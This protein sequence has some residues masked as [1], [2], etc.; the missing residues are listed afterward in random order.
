MARRQ[1]RNLYREVV[2][3]ATSAGRSITADGS[4]RNFADRVGLHDLQTYSN[5][6]E[7]CGV[8]NE[9]HAL[10]EC[11]GAESN[12]RVRENAYNPDRE[13]GIPVRKRCELKLE[14]Y[15][16]RDLFENLVVTRSTGE[17]VGR[18]FVEHY[19]NPSNGGS[20]RLHESGIDAV[21]YSLFYGI[22]GQLLISQ[23]LG[24]FI[25][26]ENVITNLCGTYQTVMM[27]GE[28]IPGVGLP[29]DPDNDNIEDITLLKESEPVRYVGFGEEYIELPSTDMHAL[30]IGITRKNLY[31]DR[32]GLIL[33]RARYVGELLSLRKEKRGIGALIGG[34]KPSL[35]FKEKRAG[36]KAITTLDPY[37]YA[38]DTSSNTQFSYA[39][40]TLAQAAGPNQA[41][42]NDIPDNPLNDYTAFRTADQYFSK[43]V[44]PNTGEPVVVGRPF[45]ILPYTRKWDLIQIVQAMNIYKLTQGTGGSTFGAGNIM[46]QT[47]TAALGAMMS[48]QFATSRQLRKQLISQLGVSESNADWIWF[49]GDFREAL[50]YSQNWPLTVVQAPP[51]STP[52]FS[53][54]IVAQFKASERGQWAWWNPRVVQRHNYRNEASGE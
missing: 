15:S 35:Y 53:Q 46:S 54:D 2:R 31:G 20:N 48:E 11:W 17:P 47:P 14:D 21:D 27:D 9:G 41:Y 40:G 24:S 19:M 50:R 38:T 30:A 34:S 32:T 4:G 39:S 10:S 8:D 7:A 22:T 45:V 12:M 42:Y 3:E 29:V 16:I 49:N 6:S 33:E 28:R 43:V 1:A 5:I 13:Y 25:R 18:S 52:E 51:N 37:Q 44:D 26:E 23:I 36:N